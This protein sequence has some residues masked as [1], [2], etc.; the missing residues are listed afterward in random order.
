[1]NPFRLTYANSAD[2]FILETRGGRILTCVCAESIVLPSLR[3]PL[4]AVLT[5]SVRAV[6]SVWE[7]YDQNRSI[8]PVGLRWPMNN[9][10]Q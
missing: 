1:M 6:F 2:F 8:V 7:R 5:F 10:E 9:H 4:E 3:L